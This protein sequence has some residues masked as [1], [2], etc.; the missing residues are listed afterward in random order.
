MKVFYDLHI[1]T[2]LSPCADDDMTPNNIVNMAMIKGLDVI[3]ITD[4]NSADNIAPVMEV[5]KKTNIRVIPGMEIETMEEVHILALFPSL[6]AAQSAAKIVRVNMPK[7]KNNESI[8]GN[9]LIFDENDNVINK[10]EQL[11]ITSTKLSISFVFDMVRSFGGIAIPAHID[12]NSYSI[13]SNLGFMPEELNVKTIEISNNAQDKFKKNYQDFKILTNSDAHN[14]SDISEKIS[15][16][17]DFAEL[18]TFF[19]K[20]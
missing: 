20:V 2:A 15:Y 19:Q 4:H 8:F 9:Q 16:F 1:H 11:L 12:R 18:E 5:A 6:A 13:I 17:D 14:L 3:A 10:E 7:I